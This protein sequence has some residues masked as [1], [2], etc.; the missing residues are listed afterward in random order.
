MATPKQ[1]YER[2]ESRY[3]KL[4]QK[5]EKA[6]GHICYLRLVVFI[7]GFGVAVPMYI[8]QNW[9]LLTADLVSF[10]TLFIYVVM[11]H[12]KL[13]NRMEYTTILRD[14]N[15]CSL[16]RIKGEWN[17]F[18]DDGGDFKDGSHKYSGD[19]D[20]FGKN[21]LFQ[22][23]NTANTYIGRRKLHELLS[24]VTGHSDD[25]RARQEAVDELAA[26]LTWRQRFSA[27]GMMAKGR[28]RD[29]EGLIDW[30]R[31]RNEYFRNFGVIAMAKIFPVVTSIL[32]LTGFALNKIPWYLPTA[33]LVWQFAL[34]SHKSKERRRILTISENYAN[35][36]KVY[37]QMLKLFEKRNFKS[38]LIK[39]IK[40]GIKN[41]EG[42]EVYRQVDRLSAIIN[43][44]SNRRNLFYVFFNIL[45]LLDFQHI[46]ALER[47]KQKAKHSL[48]KWFEALGQI[49]ALASLAVIR[50]E[51]PTWVMPVICD[52]NETVFAAKELGHPLL[53]ESRT[54]ND[55]AFSKQVKV[56]LITGSNMSGK[57]TLLRTAGINLVLAYA[58]APVCARWFQASIMEINTCMRVSDDLGENIS[59]FY[60]ELLRIKN[61][62]SEANTGKRVFY[63]FDEIFKGTNS[64]DRH[65]GAKVLI[66]KLS[67]TN[68]IGLASTHD[69]ELC[70]LEG[71]NNRIANYHFREYYRNGKIYFDYKLCPGPST[72]RNALYLMQM[73]GID[74]DENTVLPAA[75]SPR[76]NKP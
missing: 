1:K 32:V 65:T 3:N 24:G 28:M 74:V 56:L 13:K 45:L 44:I 54:H 29:P 7:T 16:K 70:E 51:N 25:T 48:N 18:T 12:E 76:V 27:E 17:T 23:I 14:I 31:E 38:T 5:Q 37:Y 35:D 68:S 53:P 61:I 50:Y 52:G 47:W 59:S 63:L 9:V 46:I 20:I 19:L 11:R 41:K 58:G 6:D 62:V 30:V 67:Q 49:E 36:L 42:L 71:E 10:T 15:S 40:D 69:L 75:C 72:T 22:W 33:A 26:M 57:S 73:A 55:L 4:L 39:G 43:S 34:L 21:S 64:M 2:R 8:L 66:N 60:A